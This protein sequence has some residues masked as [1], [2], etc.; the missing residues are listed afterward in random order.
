MRWW[1]GSGWSEHVG[2]DGGTAMLLPLLAAPANGL[3]LFAMDD[4][5]AGDGR[6]SGRR[7]AIAGLALGIVSL[8][9]WGVGLG[10]GVLPAQP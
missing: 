2:A 9:L 7:A 1:D 3:A 5:R 6:M 4:V 8:S 10:L